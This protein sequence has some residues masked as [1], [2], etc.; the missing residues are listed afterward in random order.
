MEESDDVPRE[1]LP[2]KEYVGYIWI[3]DAPGLRLSVWARSANEAVALVEAEHGEGHPL[4][5]RN[6]EDACRP[7]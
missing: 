6:E 4:S 2:L 3:G 7:R 1:D 5:L